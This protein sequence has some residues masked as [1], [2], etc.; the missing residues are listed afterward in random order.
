MLF[1][2]IDS[3]SPVDVSLLLELT[4]FYWVFNIVK[5]LKNILV[6]SFLI[7]IYL[8]YSSVNYLSIYL[9]VTFLFIYSSVDYL[10]IYL[11]LPIYLSTYICYLLSIYSSVD[12]LSIYLLLPI[13]LS[14]IYFIN[15]YYYLGYGR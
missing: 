13:Y 9:S 5:D 12:Y 15:L 7:I 4:S 14:L 3:W 2:S 6:I 8:N 11:L 10:S 1:S